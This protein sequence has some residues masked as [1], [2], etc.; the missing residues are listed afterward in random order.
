MQRAVNTA[1]D[2]EVFLCGSHISIAGQRIFSMSPPRDYICS[3]VV[4]QKSVV[5]RERECSESSAA[6]PTPSSGDGNRSGF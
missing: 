3:P 6:P 5:E 1:L 2:E 4:N